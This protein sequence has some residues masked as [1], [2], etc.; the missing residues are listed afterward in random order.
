M[1]GCWS[2]ICCPPSPGVE[3][4]V[5]DFK[6]E[7]R[8]RLLHSQA[9]PEAATDPAP[10]LTLQQK[11]PAGDAHAQ[12]YWRCGGS[13][14]VHGHILQGLQAPVSPCWGCLLRMENRDAIEAAFLKTTKHLTLRPA[15]DPEVQTE[16][17]AQRWAPVP[18]RC[19]GP[20]NF[21]LVTALNP[22]DMLQK[23]PAR[24]QG[25][26]CCLLSRKLSAHFK[27]CVGQR[28]ADSSL[29]VERQGS[30][31]SYHTS[32]SHSLSAETHHCFW[33]AGVFVRANAVNTNKRVYPKASSPLAM[34]LWLCSF[35]SGA[36]ASLQTTLLG[37]Q[38]LCTWR[39]HVTFVAEAYHLQEVVTATC[40]ATAA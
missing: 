37:R 22:S 9:A 40:C 17:A 35:Q 5:L 30:V 1:F 10:Q 29:T 24:Q 7:Q 28:C 20:L 34:G 14:D 13:D 6:R 33:P 26:P 38:G 23:P 27:L 21:G 19:A 18:D 36:A 12:P 4:G 32:R 39:C 11:V 16:P 8:H 2:C 31:I 3:P 15:E 25:R